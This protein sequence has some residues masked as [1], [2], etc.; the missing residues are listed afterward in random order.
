MIFRKPQSSLLSSNALQHKRAGFT[1]I[2][3][4]IAMVIFAIMATLAYGGLRTVINT[5]SGVQRQMKRLESLQRSMLFLE[6][7]IR[8][9]VAR[10]MNTDSAKKRSAVELTSSGNVLIEF[11][12]GG[13]PN[14][15]GLVR[16]G[17]QRVRYVLDEGKLT[18]QAW[19]HVDHL[20]DAKPIEM[21]LIENL[22]KVEFRLLDINNKWHTSWGKDKKQFEQIPIAVELTLD[23]KKWG[24]IR[25]LIPVYGF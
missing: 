7:D 16:S 24:I 17:L 22:N 1:L 25:R 12:R 11:T 8:Q 10:P 2:E 21:K 18:R 3:L 4:L 14:P 6:R 20:Q 13:N 15:A 19:G 9:L 23:H 5:S